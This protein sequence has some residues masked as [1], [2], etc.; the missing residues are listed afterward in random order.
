MGAFVCKER[1]G[2]ITGDERVK[3]SLGITGTGAQRR[4]ECFSSQR[5]EY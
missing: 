4:D 1:L 3:R 5:A 2:S